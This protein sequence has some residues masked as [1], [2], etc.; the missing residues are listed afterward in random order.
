MK[1]LMETVFAPRWHLTQSRP[2]DIGM[3]FGGEESTDEKDACRVATKVEG[4][5]KAPTARNHIYYCEEIDT[6]PEE[7]NKREGNRA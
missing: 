6:I 4:G 1:S 2:S 5:G 3:T 7:S